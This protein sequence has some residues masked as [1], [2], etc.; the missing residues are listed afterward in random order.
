MRRRRAALWRPWS[1]P[2]LASVLALLDLVPL[3]D[4][5]LSGEVHLGWVRHHIVHLG[6]G[7]LCIVYGRGGMLHGEQA[8]RGAVGSSTAVEAA[9]R[10]LPEEHGPGGGYRR[11]QGGPAAGASRR[12]QVRAGENAAAPKYEA[13]MGMRQD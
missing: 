13:S 7:D 8:G 11:P 12:V 5:A 10:A 6:V 4:A 1:R 2:A 9:R 3:L